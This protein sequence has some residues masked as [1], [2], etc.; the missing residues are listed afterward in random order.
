MMCLPVKNID[1]PHVLRNQASACLTQ[2]LKEVG[3]APSQNHICGCFYGTQ[4]L[5]TSLQ[6][7]SIVRETSELKPI[8]MVLN[9]SFSYF[10]HPLIHH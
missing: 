9:I 8:V 4:L 5:L 2:H 1:L 7:K 10:S 6:R 3:G